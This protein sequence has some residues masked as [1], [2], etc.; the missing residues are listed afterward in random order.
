[1]FIETVTGRTYGTLCI[2]YFEATHQMLLRIKAVENTIQFSFDLI[3]C[4]V[5]R[6]LSVDNIKRKFSCR[7][8]VL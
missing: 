6:Y 4:A 5:R 7:G 2:F 8:Y 3:L 1:M